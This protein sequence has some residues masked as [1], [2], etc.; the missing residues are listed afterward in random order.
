MIR[1]I[2][3]ITEAKVWLKHQDRPGEIIRVALDKGIGSKTIA[4]NLYHA[5]EN[6]PEYLGRILFDEEGYWIY[7]GSILSITEQEQLAKFIINYVKKHA[8]A[9]SVEEL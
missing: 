6:D 2:G 1:N 5:F 7:D 4:Y 8:R 3:L 9:A